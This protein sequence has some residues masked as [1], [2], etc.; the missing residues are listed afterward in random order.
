MRHPVV[1]VGLE[2]AA[3]QRAGGDL[4]AVGPL[5]DAAAARA[6]ARWPARR[7]GRSRGPGCAR[8][9]AAPT[10]R[11]PARRAPRP[12]G[13][14]RRRRAGRG[15]RRARRRCP[16]RSGRR[17]PAPPRHP[18]GR[19]SRAAGRR[20]AWWPRP[21]LDGHLAAGDHRGGQERRGVG[22]VG[23]DRRRPAA[24]TGPGATR[25][26]FGSSSST[27][28]PCS[29]SACTVMSMCGRDG[30]GLPSWRTSTPSSYAAPASSSAETN[31]LEAEASMT[32][33]PP[34]TEPRPRT[35]NGS[36]PRPSS[37]TSTPRPR[38]AS[39]HLA[40]SGGC[41]RAGRRRR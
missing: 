25:H 6:A 30:T 27:S 22:Q 8:C 9:P 7:A 5:D 39:E 3:A 16:G 26:R 40:P 38:S 11:R 33:W 23:L 19:G 15:R 32:T 37:S 18:S 24:R 20:P 36:V 1:G 28:T 31:W 10:G 34:R 14:A 13:S 21:A 4:Q 35:V 12:P 41:G 2:A 17:R 29:R